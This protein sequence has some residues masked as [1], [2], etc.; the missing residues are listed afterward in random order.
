MKIEYSVID[1]ALAKDVCHSITKTLPEWFGIPAANDR[2]EQGM[3]SRYSMTA[4]LDQECIG[5]ITLDFPSPTN[6]NIYW[7][8]V[9]RGYHGKG[10]GTRLIELAERH[11][12]ENG[13]HTIT[14][15]TLSPKH[16]DKHYQKT[17][18]FY[19]KLG[20]LKLFE[21]NTYTPDQLMVYMQKTISLP[22]FKIID[23]THTL[24]SSVPHWG[25][26]CGYRQTIGLDYDDCKSIVKFRVQKLKMYSGIGTHM[27]A[28]S[29]TVRD[30]TNIDELPI[31]DLIV[32]CRVIDVSTKVTAS[33]Q[34]SLDDIIEFESTY[35]NIPP[36]SLVIIHTGWSKYWNDPE[37]YRN[38]LVFPSISLEAATF[39]LKRDVVGLGID[40]LSPDCAD[41]G[42][43]V[44]QLF[45]NAGKYLIENIAHA[46]QLG[47][48]AYAAALPL[49]I[50]GATES[51]IRLVGL[52]I[53]GQ[54]K[55]HDS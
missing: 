31:K 18:H 36:Q 15:E 41:S 44:H 12:L 26:D 21:L 14:V 55:Y 2:Y 7:M 23:L 45:L 54:V 17:Y 22:S 51:P 13:F 4:K 46:D 25:D 39:L 28:P 53:L 37:Q 38:K 27:D 3:L 8:G 11:C 40:T 10:I 32:A 24:Q 42:F 19:E 33:Y 49:K 35:G 9:K 34:L 52:K 1:A 43:P 5:L 6:A 50:Q 29:H 30:G 47:P 48:I 16:E 20:F